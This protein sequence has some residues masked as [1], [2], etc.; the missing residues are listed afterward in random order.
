MITEYRIKNKEEE[1]LIPV[2]RSARKSVGLEVKQSGEVIARIPQGL[3]D[4][5]LKIFI[6]TH[7]KWIIDKL[8]LIAQRSRDGLTVSVPP[9]EEL[10]AEEIESI[11]SK[12]AGRVQYYGR[13]MS[14]TWGRIT[15]RN[16]KTRWGSCNAKGNL[17]FNYKLCY[18][19]LELLDYVVVHELA[20]RKHMNHSSEFWHEVEYYYPNYKECRKRLKQV[21]L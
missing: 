19:S 14:V 6:Q 12:I 13:I 3:S 10:T 17:N 11:K 5:D 2:K 9:P 20:H 15:I 7:Q 8:E 1:I 4:S 16:Q 18:L 21:R